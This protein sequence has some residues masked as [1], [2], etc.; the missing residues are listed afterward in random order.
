[1][2]VAANIIVTALLWTV[3]LI[4]IIRYFKDGV[5]A[6]SLEAQIVTIKDDHKT[7]IAGFNTRL[8]QDTDRLVREVEKARLEASVMGED[9]A[10]LRAQLTALPLNPQASDTRKF[11]GRN[12]GFRLESATFAAH[13]DTPIDVL[14]QVRRRIKEGYREIPISWDY[15]NDG[16][17]P[18]P[19]VEKFLTIS[20][21]VTQRE[22]W[23]SVAL[24]NGL[25]LKALNDLIVALKQLKEADSENRFPTTV[26]DQWKTP[27]SYPESLARE[28][29]YRLRM[30][31]ILSE[32]LVIKTSHLDRLDNVMLLHESE[33]LLAQVGP[34]L[35]ESS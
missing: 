33:L 5:R 31:Q 3:L 10:R 7:Q 20:F 24:P 35:A 22:F 32:M 14:G 26:G 13:G 17:D 30:V 21:S 27:V 2:L 23:A 15:L 12:T 25:F 9:N 18:H 6:K 34:S 11:Y 1:M 8:R 19:N 29:Q 28:I 4:G 16:H